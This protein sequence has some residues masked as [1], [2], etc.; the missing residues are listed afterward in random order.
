MGMG[1]F[2]ASL[3]M[4]TAHAIAGTHCQIQVV[5][6]RAVCEQMLQLC[7][8]KEWTAE[9]DMDKCRACS[10]NLQVHSCFTF[11]CVHT[12]VS[13]GSEPEWVDERNLQ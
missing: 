13:L 7:P 4:S 2:T 1:R 12:R 5:R 11:V 8:G 3:S 6:K 9:K 10:E